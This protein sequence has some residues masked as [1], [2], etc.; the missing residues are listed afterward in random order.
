MGNLKVQGIEVDPGGLVAGR[1]LAAD[2]SK[3]DNVQPNA[4]QNDTDANLRDRT[5]HTGLQD[6]TTISDFNTAVSGN[7][8]VT[9]NTA[10]VSAD[11]SVTT[12]NDVT[13]AGSGVI[14]SS[15]ERTTLGT[16]TQPGD[17]VSTLTN[18]VG[19]L[20]SFTETDPV[21]SASEASNF[22]A[23]D[24]TN[25]DNQSGTNTGDETTL[26]I[27]TKRPL[28][29]I[30]LQ[31]LEGAGDI[32]IT[33]GFDPVAEGVLTDYES[34]STTVTT[35]STQVFPAATVYW[36]R[37]F[38][39]LDVNATYE[40]TFSFIESGAAANTSCLV[41][42]KDFNVSVLPEIHSKEPKDPADRIFNTIKLRLQPQITSGGQF[43][44]QVDLSTTSAG[45][46]ST[47]YY[48]FLS[49]AKIN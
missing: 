4:T 44:F 7:A 32:N 1:D 21:F 15:A 45:N 17:N 43:S 9:A 31:S 34:D 6:S 23:G 26:S 30:N 11:G 8:D 24:K 22:V 47:M 3:I 48:A 38:T 10:K 40:V 5:T 33:G 41:D 36:T 18:D 35:S 42:L 2:G 49:I 19:Y 28:K 46:P 12:H 16:A 27:Q 25:L 29:T 13:N 14:I 37:I 39:G 20:T